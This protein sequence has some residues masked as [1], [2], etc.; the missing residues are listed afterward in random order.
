MLKVERIAKAAHSV[1]RAYCQALGDDSHLEWEE[2]PDWQRE[3]AIAGV[4]L[5]LENPNLTPEESHLNWCRHKR[6]DGW[7]FG[8]IKDAVKKTHPCLVDYADLALE[9]RIKDYLFK[10]VVD[11][12]RDL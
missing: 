9:Q 1:N 3:S 8:D 2:A 10:A 5:H 4:L 6:L 7:V 12:L 11:S